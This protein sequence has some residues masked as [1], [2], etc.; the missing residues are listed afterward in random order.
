MAEMT[1]SNSGWK[2][3]PVYS[4]VAIAGLLLYA[5]TLFVFSIPS[6]IHGDLTTLSVFVIIMVVSL[7]F[8]GLIWRFGSWA[9]ALT[10]LWGSLELLF[11]VGLLE[12]SLRFPNSFFDFVI[13]TLMTVGGLL[14]LVGAIV[15]FVQ[16]R[17]GAARNVSTRAE[18]RAF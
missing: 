11:G 8:A 18:R 13:P 7:I 15:A 14:T 3:R 5:L 4:R 16:L 12:I 1:A 6:V 2:N 17:R 9:L 10:A